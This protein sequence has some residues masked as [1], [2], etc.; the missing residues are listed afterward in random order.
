MI[1]GLSGG[2][3]NQIF[4]YA[5]GKQLAE[6][7]GQELYLDTFFYRQHPERT[8]AL[9]FY[10]VP[11]K[12]KANYVWHNKIRL[13]VQRIPIISDAIGIIKEKKE[14]EYDKRI[15]L[16]PYRYYVGYWQH[17]RY[18]KDYKDKLQ[19]LF[20]YPKT[21]TELQ[22]S[23]IADMNQVESVAVHVRHGDYASEQ[24]KSV[25]YMQS[26][27]YYIKAM[28]YL[29]KK[30][31]GRR[32]IF[33]FFSDDINWCKQTFKDQNDCVFIDSQISE[34]EHS[35]FMLMRKCKHFITANSTFSWWGAWLK[36]QDGV[37]IA[38]AKWYYDNKKNE[39]ALQALIE[40][41]WVV[42]DDN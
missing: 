42:I 26:E 33:Y 22:S 10:G 20:R 2:L 11:Y 34:D 29:R 13:I 15:D 30:F 23:L 28:D 9:D 40:P 41:E 39:K 12:S 38:P 27:H 4:Q 14:F 36:E 5:I 32:L 6:K 18:I 7:Y 16:R 3:G 17:R 31:N 35:D 1:I 19:E 8:L 21:L 25:Y 37:V 24:F